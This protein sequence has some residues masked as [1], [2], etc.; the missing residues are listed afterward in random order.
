MTRIV[1]PVI[2][3]S[4]TWTSAHHRA[5]HDAMSAVFHQSTQGIAMDVID[6]A[7]YVFT[8]R[9]EADTAVRTLGKAGFDLKK[10][11]LIGKGYHSD[12]HPIGFYTVGDRVKAWGASGAFWG[13]IWG[14][15]FAPAV[16]FLPGFGVIAMAGPVVAAFVAA[17]EG[18]IV[19]GG[20]SALGAALT[21]V[22]ASSTTVMRYETAIKA[23]KYVLIVHGAAEDAARARSILGTAPD[24]AA[25]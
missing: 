8:T 2:A 18:A 6:P 24:L 10:L 17:M 11:S 14:L 1:R 25:A 15:L 9:S 4:T 5:G 7:L 16:F 13:G 22:G 12:E 19:V 3:E 21:S 23:D 20:A